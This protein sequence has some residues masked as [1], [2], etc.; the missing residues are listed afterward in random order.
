M[1]RGMTADQLLAAL[2]RRRSLVCAI[3]AGVFAV[4]AAVV[5]TLPDVYRASA[6]IRV[7]PQRPGEEMV[8]RT[9][10]ELIEQR[11]LTVRQELLSRPVLQRAI[12]ELG[13]Y[14][15]IVKRKGMEAGIEAMRAD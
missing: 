5:A 6:V 1:E 14:P 4:G 7:Q 8:Q 15:D 2:W 3:F 9:V 10:S 12:Q 13:L 11:L